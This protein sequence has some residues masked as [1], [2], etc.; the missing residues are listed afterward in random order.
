MVALTLVFSAT[1]AVVAAGVATVE[2]LVVFVVALE[3]EVSVALVS[4]EDKPVVNGRAV[5]ASL[6]LR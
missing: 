1:E 2:A 5:A 4:R 6:N 3:I